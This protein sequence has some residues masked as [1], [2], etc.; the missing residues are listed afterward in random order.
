MARRGV[1]SPDS[2]TSA[3]FSS[4]DALLRLFLRAMRGVMR[5]EKGERRE[6]R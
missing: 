4:H 1:V 5:E 2:R 3:L 6:V